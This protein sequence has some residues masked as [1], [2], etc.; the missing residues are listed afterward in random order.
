MNTQLATPTKIENWL[1]RF[2]KYSSEFEWF[3]KMYLPEDHSI[4]IDARTENKPQLMMD[5]M[6]K[7]WFK[8]PDGHFNIKENPKGWSEFL[9]LIEQ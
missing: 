9:S 7:I 6:C 2:D 3:M 5:I 1:S 8:L 4:L